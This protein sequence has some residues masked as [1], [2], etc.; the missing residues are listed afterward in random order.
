MDP[1]RIAL[2]IGLSLYA[3]SSV[4][5]TVVNTADSTGETTTPMRC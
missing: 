5:I 2:L 3:V 4:S 1:A